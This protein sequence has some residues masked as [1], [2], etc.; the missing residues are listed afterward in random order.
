MARSQV[1]GTTEAARHVAADLREALCGLGLDRTQA[2][3][4]I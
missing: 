4:L 3:I 2:E 1:L